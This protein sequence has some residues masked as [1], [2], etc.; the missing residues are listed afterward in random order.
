M[1]WGSLTVLH[2]EKAGWIFFLS[3]RCFC[4][5]EGFFAQIFFILA[6][7][8]YHTMLLSEEGVFIQAL[9]VLK[10]YIMIPGEE[11]TL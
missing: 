10:Y 6:H 2:F 5:E 1:H 8:W 4:L 11:S 7:L 3:I 9:L